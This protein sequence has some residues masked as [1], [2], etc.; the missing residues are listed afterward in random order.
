M[1]NF[2]SG[3]SYQTV[4]QLLNE[5]GGFHGNEG[6]LVMAATNFAEQLDPAL[7]RAGRFDVKIQSRGGD[8]EM[9]PS[10]A[11]QVRRSTEADSNE[12]AENAVCV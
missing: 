8:R 11:S 10:H 4:N 12:D 6:I 2:G 5:I 1:L 9:T 3:S 7:T